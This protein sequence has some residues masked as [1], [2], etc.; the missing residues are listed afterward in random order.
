MKRDVFSATPPV[1]NSTLRKHLVN[2]L[3]GVFGCRKMPVRDRYAMAACSAPAHLIQCGPVDAL[4][5]DFVW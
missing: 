1:N 4:L 3:K 5:R 2:S